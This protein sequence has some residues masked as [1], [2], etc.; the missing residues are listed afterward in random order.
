M[1][2]L[3]PRIIRMPEFGAGEWLQSKRPLTRQSLRGRVVLIDFWDYSC[4]NCLRTLPYLARWHERY[5]AHGLTIIGVH[6]PEF[7]FAQVREQV[8]TAVADYI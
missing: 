7:K 2:N 1:M 8:E 4:V 5:H 6:S 3:D